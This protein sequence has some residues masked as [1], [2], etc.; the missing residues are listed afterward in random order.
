VYEFEGCPKPGVDT[1]IVAVLADINATAGTD[2]SIVIGEEIELF[3]TGGTS[4]LWSPAHGLSST[5]VANPHAIYSEPYDL[6]V[7]RVL[8]VNGSCYD[9]AFVRVKV[10]STLP[11][12]FVPT[13]FTPNGDGNNDVLKPIAVGMRTIE[14]FTIYNRY[15]QQVFT[16]TTNGQ[17]WDGRIK[18]ELQATNTYVWSVKAIDFTGKPYTAKGT[19]VLIR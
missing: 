9:S 11:T 16:T 7:Y 5:T 12:V 17:G 3:A 10:F 4:Y 8:V 14:H 13:A 6:I 19:T 18:G 15:G 1:V 2:T